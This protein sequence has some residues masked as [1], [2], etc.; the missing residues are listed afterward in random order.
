MKRQPSIEQRALRIVRLYLAT[1]DYGPTVKRGKPQ[2][3]AIDDMAR[4]LLRDVQQLEQNGQQ[5]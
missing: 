1:A 5:R 3:W 4:R 2:L